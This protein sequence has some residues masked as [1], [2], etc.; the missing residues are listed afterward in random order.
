MD[1]LMEEIMLMKNEGEVLLVMDGNGHIGILGERISRNGK[2]LLTVFEGCE[3]EIMNLSQ[4]CI[5]KVT[6][7]AKNKNER[8]SAIDFVIA[9]SGFSQCI[10]EVKIDED[11]LHRLKGKCDSDHNS[12][13]VRV[14]LKNIETIPKK[15]IVTWK[16]NAPDQAWRNYEERLTQYANYTETLMSNK[17]KTFQERYNLWVSGLTK[18]MEN[19]IGK[20]TIKVKK[21]D[22][23]SSSVTEMRSEKRKLKKLYNSESNPQIKSQVK[24]KYI[25]KQKQLQTLIK[26][27]REAFLNEKFQK[28]IESGSD[29]FWKERREILKDDTAEWMIT[30]NE[31]G[32][33]LYDPVENMNNI[34]DYYENLYKRQSGETNPYHSQVHAE[35]EEFKKNCSFES[36]SYNSEPTLEMIQKAIN[37]KKNK[38]AT[39]DFKNEF[40][41]KGG[42][43]MAKAIHWVIKTVWQEE[44]VPVQW[45]ES[46]ITSVWK[47]KGDREIMKNQ[48]GISVSSSIAMILEEI[49][50]DR[51]LDVVKFTPAQGGGVKN[52]S[53][54]DHV[55]IL[56]S[57]ITYSLKMHRQMILTFYDVAKAYDHAEREDMMHIMWKKGLRGK[58]WRI[59]CALN[60]NLTSRI[61]TPHGMTRQIQREVGGKQGGKIMCSTFAKT[62]DTL[63]EDMDENHEVG[64]TIKDT[65]ISSLLFVDDVV[66]YGRQLFETGKN[67]G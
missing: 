51:I 35:M 52:Y 65:K 26:K 10:K 42:S 16:M 49:I 2:L 44:V 62:M 1:T 24:T 55:F 50:N 67:S 66:T 59:M 64:I 54:C 7:I 25:H 40:L 33:R 21:K 11:G 12:I 43:G 47:K 38:K 61:K 58:L 27:E 57:I 60:E 23:F 37:N 8:D 46:T 13:V 4:K 14:S 48:R 41:K 18:I 19:T 20:T 31:E 53:T 28:M 9:S 22:K 32:K 6:R 63:A 3:M 15:K 34:A 56:R 39:T 17:R 5:G 36:E 30:K 45:N 29:G